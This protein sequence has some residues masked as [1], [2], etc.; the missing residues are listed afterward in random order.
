MH[1]RKPCRA[2]FVVGALGPVSPTAAGLQRARMASLCAFEMR[3][4]APRICTRGTGGSAFDRALG[5][6]FLSGSRLRP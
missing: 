3:Y 5:V 6:L 1:Y 2:A 4:D